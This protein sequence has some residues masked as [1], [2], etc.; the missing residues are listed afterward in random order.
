MTLWCFCFFGFSVSHVSEPLSHSSLRT[1]RRYLISQ[2]ELLGIGLLLGYL[3]VTTI[4]YFSYGMYHSVGNRGGWVEYN[5]GDYVDEEYD[6]DE[7]MMLTSE[8]SMHGVAIRSPRI[9]SP[10]SLNR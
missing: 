10:F 5:E 3:T 8:I 4:F 1:I 2:L 9:R 7:N 6:A